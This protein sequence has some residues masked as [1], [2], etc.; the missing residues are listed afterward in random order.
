MHSPVEGRDWHW[1]PAAAPEQSEVD[2]TARPTQASDTLSGCHRR[3][4]VHLTQP[5]ELALRE[6]G[7]YA[8]APTTRTFRPEATHAPRARR[9]VV[10]VQAWTGAAH[11][12]LGRRAFRGSGCGTDV[13]S[14]L[15]HLRGPA[16]RSSHALRAGG[17][18]PHAFNPFALP[19]SA[20]RRTP[21]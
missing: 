5:V 16:V 13:R 21:R 7:I 8:K 3:T 20:W 11:G 4:Q 19:V 15:E 18:W 6:G 1:P 9:C 12:P 10:A 14:E 2:G 17:T